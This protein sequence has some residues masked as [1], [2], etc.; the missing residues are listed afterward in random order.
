[1]NH[2]LELFFVAFWNI[3]WYLLAITVLEFTFIFLCLMCPKLAMWV[4][5]SNGLS[6]NLLGDVLKDMNCHE[7]AGL[8]VVMLSIQRNVSTF[9][10]KTILKSMHEKQ[11]NNN[12]TQQQRNIDSTEQHRNNNST[13]QQSNY[14][15]TP[16]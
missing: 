7:K 8:I 4:M 1:M 15:G 6:Q 3:A 9:T 2:Y 10:F 11:S 13:Q 5:P 16:C 12:S 14:N